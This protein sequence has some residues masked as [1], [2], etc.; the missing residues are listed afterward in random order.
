MSQSRR[1]I[2]YIILNVFVSACTTLAVL[3]LWDRTHSSQPVSVS[4]PGGQQASTAPASLTPV[5]TAAAPAS[6]PEPDSSGSVI[7]IENVFG[8]GDLASEVVMIKRTGS[9]ELSLTGWQISNGEE[10]FTFPSLTLYTGGAVQVHTAAGVNTV[11]DLFWGLDHAVWQQGSTV[12]LMDPLGKVY[13]T[14]RIP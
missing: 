8:A 3:I 5:S 1:L 11:V 12:N 10:S 14:F 9:G 13:A 2:F 6:S 4:L 7:L